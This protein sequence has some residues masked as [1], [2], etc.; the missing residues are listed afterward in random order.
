MTATAK[1]QYIARRDPALR[2]GFTIFMAV[3]IAAVG[4]IMMTISS[5]PTV[6]GASFL[7]LPA[8]LQLV[9]GVWLGPVYGTLAAGLGAYAA[10]ILAYGGWGIVDI[11]MNPLAGG[12]ANALLPWLLFSILRIDPTLGTHKPG[13]VLAGAVRA[14][15][16]TLLVLA[17]GMIAPAL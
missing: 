1:A 17:S 6:K 15:V 5:S 16:L 9:A 13:E 7:W 3:A 11:I 4:W 10:G 8:A 2:I 14:L 12:V